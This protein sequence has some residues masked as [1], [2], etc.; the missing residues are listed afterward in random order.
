ME[1]DPA[2]GE[3]LLVRQAGAIARVREAV[4]AA[5]AGDG[6]RVVFVTGPVGSGKSH[7]L[8][9]LVRTVRRELPHVRLAVSDLDGDRGSS[10]SAGSGDDQLL[11][12]VAALASDVAG[13][14]VP[15]LSPGLQVLTGT[16]E[17]SRAAGAQFSQLRDE[18]RRGEL[19]DVIEPILAAAAREEPGRPLVCVID[20]ANL[21]D[22]TW[23]LGLQ[24]SLAAAVARDLPLVLVLSIDT[25]EEES[26]GRSSALEIADS[27]V[28]RG[29]ADCFSLGP[30]AADEVN[31]W[32]GPM[33]QPLSKALVEATG[34]Y[35]GDLLDLWREIRGREDVEKKSHGWALKRGAVIGLDYG[36]H[37]L[38]K[39]VADALGTMSPERTELARRA[40]A[41]AALEG[42]TF[43]AEAV[44]STIER[45]RDEIIDLLDALAEGPR[46]GAAVLVEVD[47]AVIEDATRSNSRHLWRYR[48]RQTLDWRVARLRLADEPEA[49]AIRRELA[50]RLIALYEPEVFWVAHV[51]A[52]LLVRAGEDEKAREFDQLAFMRVSHAVLQTLSRQFMEVDTTE[53]GERELRNAAEILLRGCWEL[54]GNWPVPEVIA[55][56]C[57]AEELATRCGPAGRLILA[58]SL[59]VRGRHEF[60][61]G[62]PREAQACLEEAIQMSRRETPA[63]LGE[64]LRQLGSLMWQSGKFAEGRSLLEEALEVFRR[65]KTF[66]AE[67]GCLSELAEIDR[68]EKKF[69]SALARNT[70]ALASSKAA[71]RPVNEAAQIHQRAGIALD[72]GRPEVA[73]KL[74]LSVLPFQRKHRRRS[75]EAACLRTLG[76]AE[77]ALGRLDAAR[78]NVLNAVA[79]E[80]EVGKSVGVG[81]SLVQLGEIEFLAGRK[82]DARKYFEL[83][84]DLFQMNEDHARAAQCRE[85]LD[86]LG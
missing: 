50:N 56:A 6:G 24:F 21:L 32:I 67:G 29:L 61:V 44:A 84:G 82:R 23:W 48:F 78:A 63:A 52:A 2:M 77:L 11:A 46:E 69:D 14:A 79:L 85:W 43:T 16:I 36:A 58:R 66:S 80:R 51:V 53:W 39:R 7:L 10:G 15:L 45:G 57:R 37:R 20:E 72:C 12:S 74:V 83:A 27:L 41:T 8:R 42:A 70:E 76:I 65:Q 81:V 28:K 73:R 35:P 40:L 31:D 47:P 49:D 3:A 62:R 75:D 86:R 33:S 18:G 54:Q 60:Q 19:S 13:L 1:F 25:P 5:G 26:A 64:S 59:C 22:G 38:A 30:L 55:H 9:E 4:E 34:G 17:V 71:G 68:L